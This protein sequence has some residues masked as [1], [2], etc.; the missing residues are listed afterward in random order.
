MLHALST[1]VAEIKTKANTTQEL[2][3]RILEDGKE[4]K[5]DISFTGDRVEIGLSI[6]NDLRSIRSTSNRGQPSQRA[7]NG[8]GIPGITSYTQTAVTAQNTQG[9]GLQRDMRHRPGS[10]SAGQI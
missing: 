9:K 2:E 1:Q 8:T 10:E 5:K 6:L 4:L 7:G 3:T